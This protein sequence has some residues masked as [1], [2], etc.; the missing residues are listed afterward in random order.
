MDEYNNQ[1]FPNVVIKSNRI[2]DGDDSIVLSSI[3]LSKTGIAYIDI[4]GKNSAWAAGALQGNDVYLTISYRGLYKA[5][6]KAVPLRI[7]IKW[8]IQNILEKVRR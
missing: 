1:D 2:G 8:L 4:Y 5:L 6:K 3:E 7:R